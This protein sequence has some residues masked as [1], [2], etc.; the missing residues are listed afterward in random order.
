[1]KQERSGEKVAV[2]KDEG[3]TSVRQEAIKSKFK[4]CFGEVPVLK[5]KVFVPKPDQKYRKRPVSFFAS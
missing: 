1:V 3:L 5:K 4:S 2:N